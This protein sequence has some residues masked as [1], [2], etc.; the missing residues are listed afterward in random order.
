MKALE[1]YGLLMA[2]IFF[3]LAWTDFILNYGLIHILPTLLC[4]YMS[5]FVSAS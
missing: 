3:S 4:C 5:A 2:H 1:I